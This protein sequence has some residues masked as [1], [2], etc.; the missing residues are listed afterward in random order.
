MSF[1][2]EKFEKYEPI[3]EMSSE[4]ALTKFLYSNGNYEISISEDQKDEYPQINLRFNDYELSWSRGNVTIST[5]NG[6]FTCD[7]V[8]PMNTELDSV[9]ISEYPKS[10]LSTKL[11]ELVDQIK[12]I[13]YQNLIPVKRFRVIKE[14]TEGTP[15]ELTQKSLM[16]CFDSYFDQL[17][18]GFIIDVTKNEVHKGSVLNT[19]GNKPYSTIKF[20]WGG[21]NF[22]ARDA[23]IESHVGAN[24]FSVE[25]V[26]FPVITINGKLIIQNGD[27]GVQIG[28]QY[29]Y[30]SKVARNYEVILTMLEDHKESTYTQNNIMHELH[31]IFFNKRNN[32][33]KV[34]PI[35]G[36]MPYFHISYLLSDLLSGNVQG[37]DSKMKDLQKLVSSAKSEFHINQ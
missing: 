1:R 34:I 37:I 31:S 20:E 2:I 5:E 25:S 19:L 16:Q 9:T 28:D 17:S 15:S 7:N 36:S 29:I 27:I 6:M 14:T 35:D 18:K 10:R 30:I 26:Q 3:C 33:R 23:Q 13:E 11:L 32:G 24:I 22:G 4:G 12:Y 8:L 21:R